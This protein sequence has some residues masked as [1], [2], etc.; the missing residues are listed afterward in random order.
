[1]A[2]PNPAA[3]PGYPNAPPPGYPQGAYTPQAPPAWQ[4]PQTWQAPPPVQYR[5]PML[6]SWMTFGSILVV[7]GGILIMVGFVIDLVGTG[8]YFG[9]SGGTNA[10]MNYGNAVQAFDALVGVGIFV[11]ILGWF[12]HQMSLARRAGH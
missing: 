5:G 8:S 4:A 7:V 11:A 1:M 12:F 2:D 9:G 10:A 3:P 6:P